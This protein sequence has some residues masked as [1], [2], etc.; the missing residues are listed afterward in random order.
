MW[1]ICSYTHCHRSQSHFP[2][3]LLIICGSLYL[4]ATFRLLH[5]PDEFMCHSIVHVVLFFFFTLLPPI[6]YLSTTECLSPTISATFAVMLQCIFVPIPAVQLASP[7]RHLLSSLFLLYFW[8]SCYTSP[9]LNWL[10]TAISTLL[11]PPLQ[12]HPPLI[13]LQRILHISSRHELIKCI[14]CFLHFHSA[15]VPLLLPH[16][17][18]HHITHR[19]I[20]HLLSF[21]NPCTCP[22]IL[23]LLIWISL[24]LALSFSVFRNKDFVLSVQHVTQCLA[25]D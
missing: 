11:R 16:F 3:L 17:F 18:F 12:V 9:N 4:S 8:L 22:V 14:N 1:P 7:F 2:C 15:S 10:P 20:S 23:V 25:Y 13:T 6:S 21:S 24:P 19:K 5:S